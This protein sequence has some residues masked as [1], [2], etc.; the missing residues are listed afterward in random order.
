[1][2]DLSMESYILLF[3]VHSHIIIYDPLIRISYYILIITSS[4]LLVRFSILT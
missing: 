2:M 4:L 3:L 1:M